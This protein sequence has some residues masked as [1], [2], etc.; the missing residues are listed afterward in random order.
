MRTILLLSVSLLFVI[1]FSAC[2]SKEYYEPKHIDGEREA[3]Y[4]LDN[5]IVDTTSSGALLEN[6]S[7]LSHE[8]IIDVKLPVGYRLLG[9]SQEWIISASIDGE[10]LLLAKNGSDNNQTLSLKKTIATASVQDDIV[11]VVFATNE[12]A[13][14]S[15]ATKSLLFKEQGNATVAVDTRI[16]QPYFLN[17][18]VLFLSL[19]GKVVI[20]NSNSS[21][22]LN[23]MIVSSEDNFNNI[24][25]FN[26]IDNN[27][28]AATSYKI[29]SIGEKEIRQKYEL[30][31]IVYDTK[32]VWISTKQGEV[33]SLS[34][35]LEFR[36]KVKFP[37]AHFI[38]MIVSDKIYLL[39][40]EGYLIVLDKDMIDYRV[41]EVDL[42]DGYVY[43]GKD[44][45]YIHD[46]VLALDSNITQ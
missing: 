45:F 33:I 32:G 38:G 4:L 10:L 14:Y 35:T 7:V 9:S 12:M 1:L 43:V 26:V 23:S 15:L 28:L 40:K 20:V 46:A 16:T 17:E 34:S 11:A 13:L 8:G 5:S 27:M 39:E 22:K 30:R 25:Y 31:D 44:R 29:L 3:N 37:F 21:E 41:Y 18:L 2:S 6:R 24:I 42:D 19:D 36:S